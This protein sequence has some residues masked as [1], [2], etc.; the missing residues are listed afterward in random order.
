VHF[1]LGTA[2]TAEL[3]IRW[4]SGTVQVL[5]G[6]PANRFIVADEE[7]GLLSPED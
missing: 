5:K 4:P 3:E 6:V 7:D 2:D 1:G